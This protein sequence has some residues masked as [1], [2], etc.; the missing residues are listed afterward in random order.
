MRALGTLQKHHKCNLVG[1]KLLKKDVS[2]R[3]RLRQAGP[4][5]LELFTL[6]YTKNSKTYIYCN[7]TDN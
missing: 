3:Q 7:I 4:G 5:G 1:F 6:I 2:Q